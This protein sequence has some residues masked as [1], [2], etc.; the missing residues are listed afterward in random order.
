PPQTSAP[1]PSAAPET[2]RDVPAGTSTPLPPAWQAAYDDAFTEAERQVIALAAQL[3]L[4]VPTVGE[5]FGPGVPLDIAWPERKAAIVIEDLD[6][7]DRTALES[8]GWTII[9]YG[10]DGARRALEKVGADVS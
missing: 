5:E 7:R 9:R 8:D 6:E 10:T 3:G 4:D 2:P 1:P